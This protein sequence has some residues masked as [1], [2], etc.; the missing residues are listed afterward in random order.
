MKL[1]LGTEKVTNIKIPLLVLTLYINYIDNPDSQ[2]EIVLELRKYEA[3][4]LLEKLERALE[5]SRNYMELK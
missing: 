4:A 1:V 2:R 5:V 3:K